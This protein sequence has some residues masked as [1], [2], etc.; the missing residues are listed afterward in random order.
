[1]EQTIAAQ[2]PQAAGLSKKSSKKIVGIIIAVL[3]VIVVIIAVV[4]IYAWNKTKVIIE[5]VQMQLEY[6]KADD[7]QAGYDLMADNF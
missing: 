5:P 4:G 7:Y 6:L 3:I 1:M 2:E